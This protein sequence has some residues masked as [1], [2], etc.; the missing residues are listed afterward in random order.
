MSNYICRPLTDVPDYLTKTIVVPASTTMYA[1]EVIVISA[2]DTGITSNQSVFSAT[3]MTT[4]LLGKTCAVIINGG[5]E[6]LSDGR[7]PEGQPDYTQYTFTAGDVATVV[8][9]SKGMMFEISN[10]SVNLNSLTAT[11]GQV[12]Y[13]VNAAYTF[14]L[15][16]AANGVPAGTY[17]S[18]SVIALKNFRV[19][20]LYGAGFAS[21]MVVRVNEPTP[22]KSATQAASTASDAAGAVVD[23]NALIAKLKAAGLMA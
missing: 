18:L 10:D 11:V 6:K 15:D 2:L 8:M 23:L 14:T 13:P 9:L 4:A 12:L 3:Q 5:F 22:R 19:G 17:S 20:G 16:S 1:G 7:R 21:T